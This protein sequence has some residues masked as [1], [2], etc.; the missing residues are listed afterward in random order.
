[1]PHLMKMKPTISCYPQEVADSPSACQKYLTDLGSRFLTNNFV[2]WKHSLGCTHVSNLFI[3]EV[4]WELAIVGL[5]NE[6]VQRDGFTGQEQKHD[7]E[8]YVKNV[9]DIPG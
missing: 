7:I 6:A 1:M 2:Y 8:K 9:Q 4:Y 5:N 3:P